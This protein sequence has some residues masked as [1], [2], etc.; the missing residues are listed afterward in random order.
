MLRD[1][2]LRRLKYRAWVAWYSFSCSMCGSDGCDCCVIFF[3]KLVIFRCFLVGRNDVVFVYYSIFFSLFMN[4]GF[5]FAFMYIY[6]SSGEQYS[7][8]LFFFLLSKF[9][10]AISGFVD[11]L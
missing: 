3:Q 6:N 11:I 4:D 9:V 2:F 7:H 8:W 10:L 5:A 1:R